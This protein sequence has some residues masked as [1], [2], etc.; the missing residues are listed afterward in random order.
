[1][2]TLAIFI[3]EEKTLETGVILWSLLKVMHIIWYGQGNLLC[4]FFKTKF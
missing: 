1:M 3:K 2:L 4:I